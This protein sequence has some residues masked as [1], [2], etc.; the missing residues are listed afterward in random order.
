M[1]TDTQGCRPKPRC[2]VDTKNWLLRA[3]V[4]NGAG[5][6]LRAIVDKRFERLG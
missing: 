3:V 1:L 2:S 4:E 6:D 5:D